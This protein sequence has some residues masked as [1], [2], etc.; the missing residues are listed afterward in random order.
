[1]ASKYLKALKQYIK[2]QKKIRQLKPKI[3]E[4]KREVAAIQKF[5]GGKRITWGES[6]KLLGKF[7]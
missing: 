2:A 1:V 7:K 3:A 6:R 5:K 4:R